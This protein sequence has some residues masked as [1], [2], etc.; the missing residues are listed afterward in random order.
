MRPHSFYARKRALIAVL[1]SFLGGGI[2]GALIVLVL[3]RRRGAWRL[4]HEWRFRIEQGERPHEGHE[5]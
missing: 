2:A 4:E 5:D 1:L 3:S